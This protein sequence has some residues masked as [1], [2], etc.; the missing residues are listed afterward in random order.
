MGKPIVP[1]KP[2]PGAYRHD[3]DR[4]DAASTS[5]AILMDNIDYPDSDLP[6]YEDVP[7]ASSPTPSGN[8]EPQSYVGLLR[9]RRRYCVHLLNLSLKILHPPN[10]ASLTFVPG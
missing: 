7:T 9:D 1:P 6:A 3:L 5:S 2:S 10:P 8:H 4:D